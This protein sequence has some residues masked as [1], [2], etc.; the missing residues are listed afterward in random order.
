METNNLTKEAE[1]QRLQAALEAL[2]RDAP[3][4]DGMQERLSQLIDGWDNAGSTVH[5]RSRRLRI[6]WAAAASAIVVTSATL[7]YVARP[8]APEPTASYDTYTDPEEA[9]AETQRAL[10]KFSLA[11]NKGLQTIDDATNQKKS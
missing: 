4:P 7:L 8:V 5:R 10:T 3:S 6:R 11:L 9:A 2:R 1:A